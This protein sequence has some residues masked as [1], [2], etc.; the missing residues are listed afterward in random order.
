MYRNPEH[1][2]FDEPITFVL[3]KQYTITFAYIPP[4]FARNQLMLYRHPD[5]LLVKFPNRRSVH[6]DVIKQ[7]RQPL[8]NIVRQYDV[9]RRRRTRTGLKFCITLDET[10]TQTI[11]M[12][13]ESVTTRKRV[14]LR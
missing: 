3:A 13:E 5:V 9:N 7:T 12:I 6:C 11:K 4:N 8:G 2:N 1:G 10:H 14:A